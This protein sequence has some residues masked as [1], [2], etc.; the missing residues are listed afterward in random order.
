MSLDSPSDRRNLRLELYAGSL[1]WQNQ[2]GSRNSNNNSVAVARDWAQERMALKRDLIYLSWRTL[3]TSNN[4]N[5]KAVP[6]SLLYVH[7]QSL[8]LVNLFPSRAISYHSLVMSI[9]A[10][11]S[12]LNVSFPLLH[13]PHGNSALASALQA[14]LGFT[15]PLD[16]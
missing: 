13:S 7:L 5:L 1:G 14:R 4:V 11:V 3:I 10:T 9:L 2:E 8:Q 12:A 6:E 15:F 16:A